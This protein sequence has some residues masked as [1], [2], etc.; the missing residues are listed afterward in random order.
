MAAFVDVLNVLGGKN[1]RSCKKTEKTELWEVEY[2]TPTETVK[3]YYLYLNHDCLYSEA[4]QSNLAEWSKK[5]NSKGYELIVTPKS[6]LFHDLVRTKETFNGKSV[7]TLENLLK[8]NFLD[9]YS[10]REIDRISEFIN[11]KIELISKERVKG[12]EHLIDWLVYKQPK[13]ENSPRLAVLSASGGIGKSTLAREISGRLFAS[14]EA[15]P[16]LIES[17]QWRHLISDRVSIEDVWDA[18]I[19]NAFKNPAGLI[20]NIEALRVLVRHKLLVPIF[21]GFDEL[22]VSKHS[23]YTPKDL[24]NELV[25]LVGDTGARILITTRETFW[26]L[27]SIGVE[28]NNVERFKLLGFDA[29][30]RKEYFKKCLKNKYDI[31]AANT[32]ASQLRGAIY[33][34]LPREEEARERLDGLPF[35][36]KLIAAYVDGTNGINL[37]IDPY[38]AD[39]LDRLLKSIC[40]RENVRHN[41]NFEKEE[42][43]VFFE[44]LFRAFPGGISRDEIFTYLGIFNISDL[45]IKEIFLDHPLLVKS[46]V[47]K[48]YW[49][50]RYEVIRTYF[51][52]RFLAKSL[53]KTLLQ[54][55]DKQTVIRLMA[56]SKDGK[57]E[58]LD[59]ITTQINILT[60]ARR[61]EA[62]KHALKMIQE[63]MES[64]DIQVALDAKMACSA[65]FHMSTMLIDTPGLS[66]REKAEKVARHMGSVVADKIACKNIAIQGEISGFDFSRFV[67]DSCCFIDVDFVNCEFSQNTVFDNCAFDGVLEFTNSNNQKH[68]VLRACRFSDNSDVVWQKIKETVAPEDVTKKIIIEGMRQC[69]EKFVKPFGFASIQYQNRFNG[70]FGKNPFKDEIWDS[71]LHED[72]II[73][74]AISN[75]K[76]GGCKIMDDEAKKEIREFFS[77]GFM[78]IKLKK[79]LNGVFK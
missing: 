22:C 12:T 13:K 52:A 38:S 72:L 66:K 24:I 31:D 35:I 27:S 73:R 62:I 75:V 4:S 45:A 7:A 55:P 40:E 30:Q 47:G 50:P 78:G 1:I 46:G 69:L 43:M 16:L 57:T 48:E 76:D 71:F 8:K 79:V 18:A 63:C 33:P 64:L 36:L 3:G 14:G 28:L 39:P 60:E 67:F 77:S 42:Q 17:A 2:P 32:I 11:P 70:K 20:G 34:S 54:E 68:C 29:E 65:L 15:I 51:I 21:D 56:L 5:S 25:G 37:T 74:H 49:E 10:P 61:D 58:V 44:E 6:D 59:W 19:S 26:D 23:V 41:L 53:Q 9:K